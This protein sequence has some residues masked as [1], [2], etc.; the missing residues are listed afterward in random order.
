MDIE[1]TLNELASQRCPREVDVTAAVMRRVEALPP[2][3]RQQ[4]PWRRPAMAAAAAMAAM[5]VAAVAVPYLRSYDEAAMADD[6]AL[7]GDYASWN[8]V[9]SAAANPYFH[10]YE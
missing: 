6:L 4:S 5:L 7:L 9:E 8:T 3:G 1:H 10:L 2:L